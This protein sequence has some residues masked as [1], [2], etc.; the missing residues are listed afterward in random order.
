MYSS[1]ERAS[2]RSL[3]GKHMK[4]QL[5]HLVEKPFIT[6]HFSIRK[7]CQN[8]LEMCFIKQLKPPMKVQSDLIHVK[9]FTDG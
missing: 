6:K 3:I 2:S 5:Q 1:N 8:K 4:L 9:V 7:E